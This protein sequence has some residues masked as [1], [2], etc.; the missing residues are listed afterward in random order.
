MRNT[1]YILAK[2]SDKSEA[3][4]TV[5]DFVCEEYCNDYNTY[6]DIEDVLSVRINDKKARDFLAEYSE[7]VDRVYS[8]TDLFIDTIRELNPYE[9]N[10]YGLTKIPG[11]DNFNQD[12]FLVKLSVH[13]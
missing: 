12:L 5:Y 3:Y 10:H 11:V 4:N 1:H 13:Y 8:M 6:F 2:A 9:F 7:V